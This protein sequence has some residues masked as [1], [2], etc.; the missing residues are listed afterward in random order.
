MHL[1]NPGF[2]LGNTMKKQENIIKKLWDKVTLEKWF[3]ALR[4]VI[5]CMAFLV[6]SEGI[7]EIP[8][9]RDFFGSGLIEGRSGWL[10]YVII[11]LV[12]FAQVAIIPIP[13]LPILVACN[14]IPHLVASGPGISGLFSFETLGFVL[15]T[16]SATLVGAI[17][18]YWLGRTVGQPAIKWV[19][20]SEKD[21]KVWSKKFNSKTGKWAYAA[22]VLFPIFPD[23]IISLVVG[24]I[25][26][27]FTFYVIVNAI[28][29]FIGGFCMLLFMRLPG[30][31]NLFG[32]STSV[33]PWTL[34]LYAGILLAA[35]VIRQVLDIK[36]KRKQYKKTKLNVVKDEVYTKLRKNKSE[37]KDLIIDYKISKKFT[38]YLATKV[39]I[40]KMFE[41]DDSNKK[42]RV[43]IMVI[44]R[45]SNYWQSI[46]DKTYD[47]TEKY[48]TF[49]EDFKETVIKVV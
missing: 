9:I 22:T 21:Y 16:T 28:C 4:L 38:T 33:I 46:F 18:S 10:V 47:L 27:N 40:I 7:F 23:D 48:T 45:A 34:I 44:C 15:L 11:W 12:M 35:I 14:Q 6:I 41:V 8:M 19:A 43:R 13:A 39:R 5:I 30:I 20:G 3:K 25:K 32:A 42:N 37:F 49:I 31:E 26:M 17:A 29:K 2:K 1:V 24:S 36:I